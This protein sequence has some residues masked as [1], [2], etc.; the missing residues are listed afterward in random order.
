MC[1]KYINVKRM[2]RRHTA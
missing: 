2:D 1:F